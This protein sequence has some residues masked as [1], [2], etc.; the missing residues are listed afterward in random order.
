MFAGTAGGSICTASDCRL[1]QYLVGTTCTNCAAG[2]YANASAYAMARALEPDASPSE[3]CRKCSPGRHSTE[4]G[5]NRDCST[6]RG[7][8]AHSVDRV[9]MLWLILGTTVVVGIVIT[10]R[11]VRYHRRKARQPAN[12][13]RKATEGSTDMDRL[14][15]LEDGNEGG[16]EDGDD[17]DGGL[18]CMACWSTIE[19]TPMINVDASSLLASVEANDGIGEVDVDESRY[20]VGAPKV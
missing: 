19:M 12:V 13:E 4:T 9:L 20:I 3:Y 6:T 1:G 15:V 18:H 10:V 5:R 8:N 7:G 2:R 17:A 11:F 16:S 14:M